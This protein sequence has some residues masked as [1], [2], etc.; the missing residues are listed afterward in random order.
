MQLLRDDA[1]LPLIPCIK[2]VDVEKTFTSTW[3]DRGLRM[4]RKKV[5][6][7][8]RR[9]QDGDL[10]LTCEFGIRLLCRK[11]RLDGFCEPWVCKLPRNECFG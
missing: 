9:Y 2:V 6:Q 7:R 10:D 1:G 4:S 8:R 11:F 5:S 3:I